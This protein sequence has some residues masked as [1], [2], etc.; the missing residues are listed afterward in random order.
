MTH[1]TIHFV[2]SIF[3]ESVSWALIVGWISVVLALTAGGVSYYHARIEPETPDTTPT[4][5][6]S[7]VAITTIKDQPPSSII[8]S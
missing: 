3:Y 7:P 4:S 8:V 6:T 2:L 1:G 5:G